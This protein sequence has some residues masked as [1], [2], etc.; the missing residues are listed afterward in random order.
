LTT[1][2]PAIFALGECAEHRGQTFGLV[3]PI[4]DQ[5][6]ILADRLCGGAQLYTGS[7]VAT[8]LK[9]SGVDL[10]SAG[11]VREAADAETL[12]FNDPAERVYRKLVVRD[13][14]L[15]GAVLYGDAADGPW[16]AEL[17]AA[18]TLV[19]AW[20]DGLIFGRDYVDM[21]PV[22]LRRAAE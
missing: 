2:D 12:V 6:R 22:E 21:R 17:I 19:G 13:G 11:S 8:S 4:W 7:S 3:G 15:A 5:A 1:S 14:R 18:G 20:R 16:F 9:V 10:F